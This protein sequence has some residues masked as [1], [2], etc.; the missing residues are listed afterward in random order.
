[1][2]Y[3]KVR[4]TSK[5]HG[6]TAGMVLDAHRLYTMRLSNLSKIFGYREALK[7]ERVQMSPEF[8]TFI[9]AFEYQ[10]PEDDSK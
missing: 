4:F 5:Q 3:I 6:S 10:F 2:G 1:M 7:M 9:E 8:N